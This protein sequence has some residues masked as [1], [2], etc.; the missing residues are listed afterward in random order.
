MRS[1]LAAHE[2][3]ATAL[4]LEI[5]ETAVAVDLP[6][7]SR[8]LNELRADGVRVSIDDFG[9]GYS[10]MSQL[11]QLPLDE[12]KLDRSFIA[13]LDRDVRAQAVLAAAIE[14]GRTL[15]LAVV[16]EGVEHSAAM[17][18][19]SPRR[20]HRAGLLLQPRPRSCR[21]RGV[22]PRVDTPGPAA[23]LEQFSTEA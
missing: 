2:V 16:A 1:T 10:S 6:R 14:L 18:R 23:D 17:R 8:V 15:G 11:L 4:T 9:V 20:R 3:P 5:T 22:P 21:L 7:A 13:N 12:L 19:S